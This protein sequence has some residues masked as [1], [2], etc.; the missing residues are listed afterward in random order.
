M[1]K[2]FLSRSVP[3]LSLDDFIIN[4]QG[5]GSE[6]DT[7]GGLGLKVELVLSEP[8]QEVGFSNAGVTD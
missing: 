7:N 4:A 6:L 1:R 5:A 8:G 2:P 3:D